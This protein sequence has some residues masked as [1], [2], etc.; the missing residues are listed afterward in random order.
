MIR[1][2]VEKVPLGDESRKRLMG[3]MIINNNLSGTP[4]LGNYNVKISKFLGK[5]IWKTG[6]V[7]G[8]K[9]KSSMAGVWELTCLALLSVLGKRVLNA[10]KETEF[11]DQEMSATR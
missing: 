11:V 2:T 5:G 10:I 6:I 7:T 1:I 9:R 4:K 3:I 8:F